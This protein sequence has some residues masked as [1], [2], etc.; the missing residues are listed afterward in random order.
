MLFKFGVPAKVESLGKPDKILEDG[1]E[2]FQYVF[3]DESHRFRRE[4]TESFSKLHKICYGK[5]VVLI[6]ATPINNYSTDIKSQLLLNL[7]K[8][9]PEAVTYDFDDD[10]D[11]IF[12]ETVAA[13]KNFKYARYM[14]L[15]RVQIRRI[16]R[17]I[18]PRLGKRP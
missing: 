14:P 2:Q 7:E 6:S 17:A 4:T 3:V 9:S 10:T 15:R 8:G 5:K 13:I 18:H 11:K 1:V 16:R 12:S